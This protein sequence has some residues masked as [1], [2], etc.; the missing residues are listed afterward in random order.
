MDCIGHGVAKSQTRLSDF[1]QPD[2]RWWKESPEVN[3][4]EKTGGSTQ[5]NPEGPRQGAER[6]AFCCTGL[7]VR[8]TRVFPSNILVLKCTNH[9]AEN[10]VT[11]DTAPSFKRQGTSYNKREPAKPPTR[12]AKPCSNHSSKEKGGFHLAKSRKAAPFHKH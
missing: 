6:L 9:T 8:Y 3:Q 7:L 10:K 5:K 11:Q 1:Q 4:S 2:G 12:Q